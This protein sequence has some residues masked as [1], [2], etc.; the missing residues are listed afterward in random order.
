MRRRRKLVTG[1]LLAAG[2]ASAGSW[3][4]AAAAARAGGQAMA[5][6]VPW[7]GLRQTRLYPH[8]A[9]YAAWKVA[10]LHPAGPAPAQGWPVLYLLD[11]TAALQALPMQ[12]H[13]G[14]VVVALGYDAPGR[15][16]VRSRAWDYTP[17][18]P[19][20][21]GPLPDPRAPAR[22]NGG[23][24]AFLAFL[25]TLHRGL[26]AELPLDARRRTLYG[27]SYGGLFV[28]H[29]LLAQPHS[30][31]RYVAASPSLWWHAPFMAERARTA[32]AG[33]AAAS[34]T[35]LVGGEEKLRRQRCGACAGGEPTQD[36][37]EAF[38]QA[39]SARGG[40][41]AALHVLPGLA[42]GQML[43]ATVPWAVRIAL[44]P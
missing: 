19:G 4:R 27:H 40:R 42:H 11:G 32:P 29:A 35:V 18:P 2:M 31:D 36:Q 44:R 8:P 16:D 7:T 9:G 43:A 1:A 24:D 33:L 30:Y 25:Q 6:A 41:R 23:A 26:A 37:A 12:A 3:A 38:V 20:A 17:L 15:F 5:P 28:L 10:I 34:L 13:D 39:L 22:R 14:L 21:P